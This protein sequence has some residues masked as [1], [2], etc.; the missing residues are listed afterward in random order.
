MKTKVDQKLHFVHEC[1]IFDF[2]P[3]NSSEESA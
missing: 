3:K 1:N 2:T